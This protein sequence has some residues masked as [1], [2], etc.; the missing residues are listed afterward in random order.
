MRNK[1]IAIRTAGE[2]DVALIEQLAR[3]I[4]PA[5]YVGILEPQHI[6]NMLMRIYDHDSLRR[7]M[8]EEGH[9]F[10]IASLSGQDVAYASG[11]REDNVA[12][13]KKVYVDPSYKKSG[14]GR[15]LIQ[16]IEDA[17][18]PVSEV[19]LLVNPNNAPAMAFYSHIGFTDIGRKPVQMGDFKFVDHIFA[20]PVIHK[21]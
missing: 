8:R 4:W 5:A 1:P 12:W 11:Y 6:E 2:N 19:R 16:V 3:R 17:F 20:R 13:V 14:L 21:G 9:R 15:A 10:W 7:E 18:M